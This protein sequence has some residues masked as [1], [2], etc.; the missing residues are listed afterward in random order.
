M[1]GGEL[2]CW[3]II[4]QPVPV[5]G[6]ASDVNA[7]AWQRVCGCWAKFRSSGGLELALAEQME[8][9]N[10]WQITIRMR[11]G[12]MPNFRINFSNRI[13]NITSVANVD[14]ANE[15]ILLTAWEGKGIS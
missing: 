1:K 10:W 13:F 15:E 3:I 5:A 11:N 14:Y 2:N 9:R 8:S 12:V 6:S 7:L 4:E